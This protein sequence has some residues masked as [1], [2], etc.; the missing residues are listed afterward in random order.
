MYSMEVVGLEGIKPSTMGSGETRT[1]NYCL[2][3]FKKSTRFLL[4]ALKN[5]PSEL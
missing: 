5:G 2:G 4:V 1:P 3:E